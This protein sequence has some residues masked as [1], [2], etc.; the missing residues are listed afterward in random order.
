MIRRLELVQAMMH[1]PKV[2]FLDEPTTGLD[3]VARYKLWEYLKIAHS[4][5]HITVFLTTHDMDEADKLCDVVAIMEKGKIIISGSPSELKQSL[6]KPLVTLGDVF[7]KY[8]GNEL[9]AVAGYSEI[10]SRRKINKRLG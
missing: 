2:L 4:L 5:F 9:E 1:R 3:I 6:N 7:I 10:Q 8:T